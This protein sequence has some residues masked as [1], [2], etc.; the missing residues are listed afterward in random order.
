MAAIKPES[1]FANLQDEE[2]FRAA[3]VQGSD[4]LAQDAKALD[5][6]PEESAPREDTAAAEAR[7]LN[8]GY[9]YESKK[10]S[11]DVEK[12]N[13]KGLGG[14]GGMGVATDVSSGHGSMEK[15]VV[16]FEDGDPMVSAPLSSSHL[17]ASSFPSSFSLL[18]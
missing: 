17:L 9:G 13:G 3:R 5:Q 6:A 16:L 4:N 18:C 2:Q 8:G 7:T 14:G 15:E 12:A 10:N 1:G 11:S